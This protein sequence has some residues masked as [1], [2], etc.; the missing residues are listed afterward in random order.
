VSESDKGFYEARAEALAARA[1]AVK[2][3][4]AALQRDVEELDREQAFLGSFHAVNGLRQ[5]QTYVSDCLWR[6]STA[7][8]R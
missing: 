3:T 4:L 7:K 1:Q 5:A 8:G 6:L 2:D